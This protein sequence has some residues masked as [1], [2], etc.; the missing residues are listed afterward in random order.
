VAVASA[1]VVAPLVGAIPEASVLPPP[2]G[3]S[4]LPDALASIA[5]PRMPLGQ[6]PIAQ[7]PT[8]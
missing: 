5:E 1:G 2:Q 7:D 8:T 6:A 4:A 3:A